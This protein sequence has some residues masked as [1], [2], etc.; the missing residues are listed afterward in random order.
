MLKCCVIMEQEK[1]YWK[2]YII[3]ICATERILELWAGGD[4]DFQSKWV[5]GRIVA[6]SIGCLMLMLME[7]SGRW[8]LVF[9]VE[10]RVDRS[11]RESCDLCKL[12]I[13]DNAAL[14]ADTEEKLY[15]LMHVFCTVCERRK[16]RV[17]KVNNNVNSCSM[18]ACIIWVYSRWR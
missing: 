1:V 8:R 5:W 7:W 18:S 12:L 11:K 15:R 17:I 9:L 4:M 10:V 2:W 16:Q 13:S 3:F 14:T 6:Y